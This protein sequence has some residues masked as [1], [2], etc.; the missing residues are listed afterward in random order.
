MSPTYPPPPPS[1]APDT[2]PPP[3]AAPTAVHAQPSIKH[4][5]FPSD[6]IG[7]GDADADGDGPTAVVVRE[8]ARTPSPTPSEKY[9][10]TH[11]SCSCNLKQHFTREKLRDRRHLCTF[12]LLSLACEGIAADP[13]PAVGIQ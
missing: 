1:I 9:V 8:I 3:F 11:K 12:T 4:T 13:S 10:L 5:I 6:K 7:E 2:P